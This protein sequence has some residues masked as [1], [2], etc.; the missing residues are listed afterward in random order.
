VELLDGWVD[1]TT[2][3]GDAGPLLTL[4]LL[5][6]RSPVLLGTEASWP[7]I[8]IKSR[9]D[10]NDAVQLLILRLF[11]AP[12][13]LPI[14]DWLLGTLECSR[15]SRFY[16]DRPTINELPLH[17]VAVNIP[18]G[19]DLRVGGQKRIRTLCAKLANN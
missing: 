8:K 15:H 9:W 1:E 13:N 11:D 5:L 14:N 7:M 10:D 19:S 17:F 2:A 3:W 18:H 6:G 16:F 12:I 4:L